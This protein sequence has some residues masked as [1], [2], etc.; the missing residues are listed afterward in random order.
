MIPP[1][2]RRIF[3]SSP[4]LAT[5]LV[6][7]SLVALFTLLSPSDS[8]ALLPSSWR[9][10]TSSLPSLYPPEL[11]ADLI[12]KYIPNSLDLKPLAERYDA[13]FLDRKLPSTFDSPILRPLARRLHEFLGR[14]GFDV[15][16]TQ[17]RNDKHCPLWISNKLV[18]PDQ[19]NGEI[20]WWESI[21]GEKIA[22]ARANVVNMLRNRVERGDA[23]VAEGDNAGTGRGIVMTGGNQVGSI[24]HQTMHLS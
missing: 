2:V 20:G 6:T 17:D 21:D 4:V 9:D 18:N 13:Y 22:K 10:Q 24:Q 15:A 23:V 5:T 16:L 1:H 12:P 19:Y 14:P 3:T 8:L 11:S 7:F